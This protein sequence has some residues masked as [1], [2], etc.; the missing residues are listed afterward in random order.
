MKY[1]FL[2]GV[3]PVEEYFDGSGVDSV[4]S[5]DGTLYTWDDKESPFN[6]LDAFDG[7]GSYVELNEV[8]FEQLRK[9]VYLN[10]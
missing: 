7:W 8:E 2:F 3:A 10:L 4:K 5:D 1:Y 6:L 9:T